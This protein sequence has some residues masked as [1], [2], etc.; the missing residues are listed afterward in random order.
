MTGLMYAIIEGKL[1]RHPNYL[2]TMTFVKREDELEELCPLWLGSGLR[3]LRDWDFIKELMDDSTSG[4]RVCHNLWGEMK[5][6]P[7]TKKPEEVQR[8]FDDFTDSRAQL[9]HMKFNSP[10]I[11]ALMSAS[12]DVEKALLS[13]LEVLRD[14]W[15]KY[16]GFMKVSTEMSL[17][18]IKG[19]PMPSETEIKAAYSALEASLKTW[20]PGLMNVLDLEKSIQ[21]PSSSR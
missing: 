20:F 19:T 8:A 15:T 16:L 13:D 5:I 7:Y 11:N 6:I 3:V 1:K 18:C 10:L 12:P 17:A 2:D 14:V 4:F 9:L 21:E